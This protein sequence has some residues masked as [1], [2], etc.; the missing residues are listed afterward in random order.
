MNRGKVLIAERIDEAGVKLLQKEMDVDLAIGIGRDE[1]L[2]KIHAYDGLIIRSDN[3]VDKELMEKA[4]NL[5]IVGRAGNG[6]D[7][8]NIEEATKRGIIVANTPDSNTISACEIAIAHI[9]AGSRNFTYADSYL[10]AGKW[11]RDLFMGNELYNKTLGIIGLGR[12]GALVATRMKAFGMQLIAYDPYISDERFK[13]YGVEKKESLNELLKEADIISI[14]TPRTKE[15]IGIIGERE[16]ALMKNGV[17]LV[18]A[19]RGKLMDEEA[20]YNGLKNG[21]IKSVG[22]DVHDKEPRFESPLYEFPNVTVTPHIG[23]TT[24]EAQENVGLTIAKQ[25]I[26]GIKGEIVPNAVNLPGISMGELK[27]L[28]PYIELIEKLGKLY[29]QLNNESVKYVDITYWGEI[30]KFDVDSMERAFLKGLLEPI[31][32]DRVNYINARIVAEQNGISIRQQKIEGQYKNYSNFITI[33]ITNNNM[34]QYT[35]AG[36][37]SSNHEGKLVEIQGYEVDVK[38]STHMLFVQNK[39]VPGV[40]GQVGTIIGM[41]NINVATMQVGRKAKG[42]IALM[43]L[44]VDSE[45]AKESLN[46]FKEIENIIEVKSTRL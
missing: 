14:H 10:K 37:L 31:S 5:K 36:S 42:E 15:T 44:N 2:E 21:K 11:E 19:A 29:Y 3:K 23:A 35:F 16:V 26:N 40:I 45:V 12:I 9:L 18:N 41:E 32:N 25:V 6:V 39:D 43:I 34:E 22:L 38:P 13:R 4:P 7:N 20:L 30:A 17:R 1:L 27:E 24:I 46:K 33:K 28:K 8:I